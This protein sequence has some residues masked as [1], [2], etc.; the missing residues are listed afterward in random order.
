MT[1]S[2]NLV[3]VPD[4]ATFRVLPWAPNV[5]WVLCDEYFRDGTPFHFSP[6]RLLKEQLDK[7]VSPKVAEGRA[8][9]AALK[10]ARQ[11]GGG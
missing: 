2:P 5:G 11:A 6:R 8:K 3:A 1:G 10:A 9:A 4:P 7:G